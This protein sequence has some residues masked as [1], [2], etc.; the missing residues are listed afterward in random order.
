[1]KLSTY[2]KTWDAC[3]ECGSPTILNLHGSKHAGIW[4]CTNLECGASDVCEHEKTT[5]EDVLIDGG[6]ELTE[7]CDACGVV[8]DV[9]LKGAL[10]L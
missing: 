1:M 10:T 6:I 3:P 5:T 9:D 4:E 8:V 7:I 2:Q